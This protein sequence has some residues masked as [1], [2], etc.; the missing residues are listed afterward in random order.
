MKLWREANQAGIK[1]RKENGLQLLLDK[2]NWEHRL[3]TDVLP[4]SEITRLKAQPS[5]SRRNYASGSAQKL[6]A[7]NRQGHMVFFF[8]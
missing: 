4:V 7:C 3:K 6:F 8:R 1:I 2:N 5:L